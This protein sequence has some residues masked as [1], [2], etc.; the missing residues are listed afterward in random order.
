MTLLGSE[1]SVLIRTKFRSVLQLRLQQRRAREQLAGQ[2]TMPRL[3]VSGTVYYEQSYRTQ[4]RRRGDPG[5]G[6][7]NPL[8]C[9]P[10]DSDACL[11]TQPPPRPAS[12]TS[13]PSVRHNMDAVAATTTI[14]L[15]PSKGG[16]DGEGETK[17]LLEAGV[18]FGFS[19]LVAC[20]PRVNPGSS[21]LWGCEWKVL[22]PSTLKV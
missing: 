14:D 6:P 7:A 4:D 20:N 3:E 19:T 22:P 15:D 5:G 18:C 12:T 17:V 1:H 13:S 16:E 10:G 11:L 21:S 8:E 9:L 2:G